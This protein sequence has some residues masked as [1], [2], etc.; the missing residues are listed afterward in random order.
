MIADTLILL[1]VTPEQRL[2]GRMDGKIAKARNGI[3]DIV[4][5]LEVDYPKL[6]I[7][8]IKRT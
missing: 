5:P 2:M 3:K 4:F 7:S 1:S 8:D 6:T